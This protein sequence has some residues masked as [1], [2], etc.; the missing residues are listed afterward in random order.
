[1]VVS[2]ERSRVLLA[3]LHNRGRRQMVNNFFIT[4]NLDKNMALPSGII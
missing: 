1:M 3:Q 2:P 4:V